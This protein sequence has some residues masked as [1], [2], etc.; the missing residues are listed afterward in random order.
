MKGY[1]HTIIFLGLSIQFVTAQENFA[2]LGAKWT[3]ST[4]LSFPPYTFGPYVLEVVAIEM[5]QGKMCS[6]INIPDSPWGYW[7]D[8]QLYVYEVNDSVFY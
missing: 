4:E 1:I 7:I 8:D 5:F 6:K 2:P 3:Y